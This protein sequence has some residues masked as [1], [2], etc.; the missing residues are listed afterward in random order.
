MKLKVE[1]G[2]HISAV[3]EEAAKLATSSKEE[4]RFTFNDVAVVV[5]PGE[6]GPDVK[7]RWDS[8]MERAHQALISSPEYKDRKKREEQEYRRK[9]AASMVETATTEAEMRDAKSPWP[10]TKEQLVEY[11]ES[12]VNRKHDY[13]T[14][15]YAMSLAAAAAFNYVARQLGTTGFQASCADLDFIRRSRSI[16]GPFGIIQAADALYPQYDLRGKVEEWLKEWEPWLREEAEKNLRRSGTA[17]PRVVEHWKS[18]AG[19]GGG[20][21]S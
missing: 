18:L 4:V 20:G 9:C 13:G 14:S 21:Q 5:Q 16:K 6:S 17:H 3:C 2:N 8:D 7:R 19:K 15:A 1:P 11:V 10:Y 12:L